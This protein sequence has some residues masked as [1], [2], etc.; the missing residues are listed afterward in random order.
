MRTLRQP[1]ELPFTATVF[2]IR[3]DGAHEAIKSSCS[4]WLDQNVAGSNVNVYF[5]NISNPQIP[6]G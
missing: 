4:F 5:D 1:S 3:Q 6:T 2:Q